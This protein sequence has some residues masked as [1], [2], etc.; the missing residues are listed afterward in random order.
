MGV[1]PSFFPDLGRGG[2]ELFLEHAAEQLIVGEAV[3]L[4]DL[5][6]RFVGVK[7]IPVNPGQPDPVQKFQISDAH[8]FFEKTA[9]VL[10]LQ[11]KAPRN[12]P[13]RNRLGIIFQCVV[14]NG[15]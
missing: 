2:M 15:F 14:K 12:F 4:Q 6:E 10:G 7:E 8:L 3:G 5:T 1:L 11:G 13:N 9:E